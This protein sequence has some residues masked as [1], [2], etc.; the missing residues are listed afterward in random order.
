MSDAVFYNTLAWVLTGSSNYSV[1][2]AHFLNTWFLDPFTGMTPNLQYAQ[3]S[4]GPTGQIG[5]HTGVL[6]VHINA[7]SVDSL[8]KP[9]GFMQRLEANDQDHVCDSHTSRW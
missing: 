3:M 1:N 6:Y 8:L 9:R 7:L 4:R 5:A 2:A